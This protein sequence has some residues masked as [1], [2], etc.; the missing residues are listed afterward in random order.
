MVICLVVYTLVMFGCCGIGSR[1]PPPSSAGGPDR[2]SLSMSVSQ[3][4]YSVS[5]FKYVKGIE[6]PEGGPGSECVVCLSGFEDGES[7]SLLR[8]CKHSYHSSCIETWLYSHS[9]CPVCRS[10]VDRTNYEDTR[11]ATD[12]NSRQVFLDIS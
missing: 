9:D 4:P 10:P 11:S 5:R 2:N 8:S 6:N 3:S 7:V 12:E 1:P